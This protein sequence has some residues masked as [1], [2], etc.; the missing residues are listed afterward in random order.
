MLLGPPGSGKSTVGAELARLG[1]RWREWEPLILQRW[2]SREH[3]V[4]HKVE[5]LLL[6]HEEILTWIQ[7]DGP[8]PVLET[9]G[10]SDSPLLDTIERAHTPLVVRLDVSREESQ[11]RVRSR[12][13][14]AHLSD[15]AEVNASVWVAFY[16]VVA[17]QRT[18]D[19]VIDTERTTA[20]AAATEIVRT[21]G[22]PR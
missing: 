12:E 22:G 14:G 7:L 16:D 6:L 9:T 1:L 4:E 15:D 19:L 20:V 18:S 10:L 8:A 11:R 5:A 13:K 3:Y 2:G 17:P 21:L